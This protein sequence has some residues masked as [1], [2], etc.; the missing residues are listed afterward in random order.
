MSEPRDDWGFTADEH[1]ELRR[2]M[3]KHHSNLYEIMAQI[4]EH[5][6]VKPEL[7]GFWRSLLEWLRELDKER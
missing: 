1:E 6:G 2:L 7:D 3:E 4:A 5:H